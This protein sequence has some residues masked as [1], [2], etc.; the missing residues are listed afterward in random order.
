MNPV[1]TFLMTALLLTILV[2]WWV[3]RPLWR[4]RVNED[5]SASRNVEA[6]RIEL[7]EL[8]RDHALGL[9][10]DTAL[11]EAQSELETRVLRESAI[12]ATTSATPR[13]KKSAIACAAT[14]PLLA[15]LSYVA[16]GSPQGLIPEAVRPDPKQ[17]ATQMDD[18]FSAVEAR[19]KAEPSDAKGW[20]LFARALASVGRFDDAMKAYETL[21]KLTPNDADAWADYADAAAGAVQGTMRGKPIAL[22]GK[23][24]AID[25]KQP[26]ALLLRGTFEIQASDWAAARKTFTLAQSVVE[27]NTGF[28]QI[29]ENALKDIE[30]RA[31]SANAAASATKPASSSN[32]SNA[33]ATLATL[34]L[35]LSDAA[36]ASLKDP[37]NAAVFVIVRSAGASGGP[38]LAA[39]KIAISDLSKPIMLS[40]S[41]AMIGGSG[42]SAG[43]KVE[44]FARLSLNGQPTP[45]TGDWQSEKQT[46]TLGSDT[47]ISI[48]ISAP[49]SA[50]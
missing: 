7:S 6:L 16:I 18:L 47:R 46:A 3:L 32:D 27:P 36:K 41:D 31:G 29:A 35:S 42:L 24:L 17:A 20:Y 33:A 19:L 28:A 15:F 48:Q 45:Q 39:K 25:S 14:L 9:L 2:V 37:A 34:T 50:K 13:Y 12:T 23:A 11:A 38:P 22:V 1:L 8:K 40:M 43:A 49:V 26:K 44:L 5:V 30:A 10:T 21:M 4:G